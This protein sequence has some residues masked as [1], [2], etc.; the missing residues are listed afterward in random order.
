MQ[1]FVN[2]ARGDYKELFRFLT[3]KKIR[4]KN[5]AAVTQVPHSRS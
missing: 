2:L 3:S 4:I 1:Q 5:I